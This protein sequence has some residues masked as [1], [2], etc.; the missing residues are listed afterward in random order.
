MIDPTAAPDKIDQRVP[1]VLKY[2]GVSQKTRPLAPRF[3]INFFAI[4]G[5]ENYCRKW[6]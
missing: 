6:I 2:F 5:A 3:E 1:R 4:G